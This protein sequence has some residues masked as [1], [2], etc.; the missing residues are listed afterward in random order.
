MDQRSVRL[1]T[2]DDFYKMAETE[3]EKAVDKTMV[4]KEFLYA[5]IK[6]DIYHLGVDLSKR[7]RNIR[8]AYDV[9]LLGLIVSTLKF[10]V[11]HIFF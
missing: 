6:K 5:T 11:C 2:F 9:Y 8:I 3:Y 7:Y 1:M 10:A 4:D